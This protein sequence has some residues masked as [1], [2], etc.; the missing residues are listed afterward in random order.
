MHHSSRIGLYAIAFGI[1]YWPFET[2]VHLFIFSEGTF[3]E[4]FF[5]EIHEVWMRLV[6]SSSFIAFGL[7]ANRVIGEQKQLNQAIQRQQKQ[8]RRVI[9]SAHDAYVSI[10]S[11]SIITDWNPTAEKMFGWTRKE[12]I[13]KT[14]METIVPDRFHQAHAFGMKTYLKDGS[15]P[16]LYRNVAT[17]ARSKDG[18]ELNVEMAIVPINIGDERIF[19]AFIRP[20]T[21]LKLSPIARE[22]MNEQPK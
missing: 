8:L 19:Y 3:L 22:V 13:G 12:A 2:L 15:G 11:S 4:L 6:V 1:L 7:Y 10:N 18:R 21:T 17:T 5:P 20:A 16:W 9:D 14:L